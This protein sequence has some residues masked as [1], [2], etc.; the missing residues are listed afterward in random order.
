MKYGKKTLNKLIVLLL[1]IVG[2][3]RF[4]SFCANMSMPRLLIALFAACLANSMSLHGQDFVFSQFYAAPLQLNPAFTGAA[5][6]PRFTANYRNQWPGW[7]N[8]YSTYCA[9]YEQWLD[10]MNS[11]VGIMLSADNA[12]NG[13]YRTTQAAALYSYQ[14]QL[15]DQLY[16]RIGVEAGL[17]QARINWN[18]LVFED[19]LSPINGPAGGSPS[20]EIP[21]ER[22]VNNAFDAS[23][24]LLVFNSR[25]H[26]GVSLRHLNSPDASFLRINSNLY[27]GTPLRLTL[28]GGF[29]IPLLTNNKSREEA[30]LSPN[31]LYATQGGFHQVNAGVYAG[32]GK[33]FAGAWFRHTFGNADAAILLGG[34]RHGVLKIGYSYDMTLSALANAGAGGAHEVS[35]G[36]NLGDSKALRRK[37]RS[38]D[39]NDCFKIFR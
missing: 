16:F 8:A 32:F 21:P 33:V 35:L 38:D 1:N 17:I 31:L 3:A 29:E 11:G 30:F 28:H 14:V 6:A 15:L 26:A 18:A 13:I 9:A 24:G 25:F 22:F 37:R 23:A 36:I 19:Q 10:G 34:F 12:G 5:F 27:A 2:K 4:V 7:P 39:L 20:N